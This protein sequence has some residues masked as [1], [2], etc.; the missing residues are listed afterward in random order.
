MENNVTVNGNG[1]YSISGF[2]DKE[3]CEAL[4]SQAEKTNIYPK[5]ETVKVQKTLE[6]NLDSRDSFRVYI[7]SNE[8]AA[9]I[10][11]YLKPFL[12]Q[13]NTKTYIHKG[14]HTNLRIYKYLPG[15]EFKKHKDGGIVISET[16]KSL[17]SLLLYLNDDFEGGSTVFAD[18]EIIPTQGLVVFFPHEKEHAG[19][20]VEKGLKYVLRG[21]L[22]F[23]KIQQK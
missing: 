23:E 7:E 14:I 18:C 3:I 21:N 12:D 9:I 13:I 11:E 6:D 16:E 15:Q 10:Y 2:W 17:Y 19:T 1:V 22:I 20:V 4:I 5:E 8:I